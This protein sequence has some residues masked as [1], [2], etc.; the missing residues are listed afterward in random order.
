MLD[1]EVLNLML[2]LLMIFKIFNNDKLTTELIEII[3][4]QQKGIG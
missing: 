2:I 1:V 4:N 3:K